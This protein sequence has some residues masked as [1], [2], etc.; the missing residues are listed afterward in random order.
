MSD[1]SLL[2]L[3]DGLGHPMALNRVLLW[4]PSFGLLDTFEHHSSKKSNLM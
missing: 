3:L 1:P 4:T 2:E